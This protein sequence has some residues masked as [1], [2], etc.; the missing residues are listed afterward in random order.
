[1]LPTP[2]IQEQ[3]GFTLPKDK[4]NIK[5]LQNFVASETA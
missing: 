3:I 4:R 5:S 1:M 2:E